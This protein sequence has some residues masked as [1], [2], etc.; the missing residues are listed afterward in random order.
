MKF[1]VKESQVGMRLDKFLTKK[2][3]KFSRSQIQKIIKN[4]DVLV[5]GKAVEAHYFLKKG[6]KIEIKK[7]STE[8]KFVSYKNNENKG[9]NEDL[10]KDIKIIKDTQDYL[11]INKP[12]GL[13]VHPVKYKAE[14]TLVDWL[15][16]KYSKIK[17]VWDKSNQIN[18]LR[19]GIVHRL[20]RDVSGLMIIAKTQ[21]MFD[22]LKN[23]FQFRKIKKEYLALVHGKIEIDNGEINRSISRSKR[24]GLMVAHGNSQEQ[25]KDAVTQFKV[26]KRF[27]NYT[28]LKIKLITGRTHQIRVHLRS[29]GHSVVGDS[30]YQTRDLKKRRL[31]NK[32]E[33]IFLCAV[34]LGFYD[35][36]N[37][38]Q[39]FNIDLPKSLT[40][41]LDRI[42]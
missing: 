17:G 29:I 28:L 11:V 34:K 41:F 38:W 5:D 32:L 15:I 20:D 8:G 13:L 33:S 7:I 31:K 26:L 19:P 27:K 21:Q 16:K 36:D 10:F 14:K 4:K 42:K 23:Q 37:K 18:K 12:A 9:E 39:E 24:T 40:E 6:D 30:L 25:G 1:E 22:N 2:L 3:P 35:L